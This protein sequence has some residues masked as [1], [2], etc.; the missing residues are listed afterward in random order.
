MNNDLTT[1]R[2][3]MEHESGFSIYTFPTPHI[4]YVIDAAEEDRNINEFNKI[5]L[6]GCADGQ[7]EFGPVSF[8]NSMPVKRRNDKFLSWKEVA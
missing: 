5:T 4:L 8:L 1:Y 2:L 6:E 7:L 3:R